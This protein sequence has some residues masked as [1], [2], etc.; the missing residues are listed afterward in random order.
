MESVSLNLVLVNNTTL[1]PL[2]T[3]HMIYPMSYKNYKGDHVTLIGLVDNTTLRKLK[4]KKLGLKTK[5]IK[6]SLGLDPN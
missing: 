6:M 1:H 4:L 3:G 5:C 2:I